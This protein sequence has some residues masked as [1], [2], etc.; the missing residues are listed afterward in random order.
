MKLRKI[1]YLAIVISCL[2]VLLIIF[3][4]RAADADVLV[5]GMFNWADPCGYTCYQWADGSGDCYPCLECEACYVPTPNTTP[6]PTIPKTPTPKTP[7]ATSTPWVSPTP[8]NPTPTG[9][10]I[11]G[12]WLCHKPGTAAEQDYC[13]WDSEGCRD[14]HLAHGDYLGKCK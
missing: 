7:T 1:D 12:I 5:E 6:T 13:C 10:P 3:G 2:L 9:I 8:Y 4:A 14:A 11:C